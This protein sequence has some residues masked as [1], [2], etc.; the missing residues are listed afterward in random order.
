MSLKHA[1]GKVRPRP[2]GIRIVSHLC[3]DTI[4]QSIPYYGEYQRLRE[5][6]IAELKAVENLLGNPPPPSR[7]APGP[8]APVPTLKDI[9]GKALPH[10]GSY[11][12]LDNKQ[13]VVALIDDV[14]N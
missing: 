14:S 7:P 12:Q 3:C 8:A 1:L 6:K 9:I 4:F 2:S 10:I 5:E 13:Q 11:K